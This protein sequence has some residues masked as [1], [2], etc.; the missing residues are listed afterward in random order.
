VASNDEEREEVGPEIAVY[1]TGLLETLHDIQMELDEEEEW[2][3][4]SAGAEA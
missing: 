4:P 1:S 2:G 3:T